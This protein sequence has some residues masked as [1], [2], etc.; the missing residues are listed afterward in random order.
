MTDYQQDL[1]MAKR[2][3]EGLL[4]VEWPVV[5]GVRIAKRCIAAE[6][7]GGD[8]YAC[9]SKHSHTLVAKPK[10]PGVVEYVDTREEQ[11]GIMIGDVAGHGVSSALVMALAS[12]LLTEIAKHTKSPADVLSKANDILL[13]YIEN[14]Q[15]RYITV[16]Y[17]SLILHSKKIIWAKA[18][19]PDALLLKPD[20]AVIPLAGEGCVLGMFDGEVY[21][22]NSY[23]LSSKD[24]LILYTDGLTEAKNNEGLEWGVEGLSQFLT[25]HT[26]LQIE[27][28]LD[29]IFE[30]VYSFSQTTSP[31]DDQ[32]LVIIEVD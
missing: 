2:V 20:G 1:D 26:S 23:A 27:A 13:K 18:G 4:S 10:I 5:S 12:G 21:A 30:E 28:L 7:V 24:R 25:T 14:S 6:S 17:F 29:A 16:L 3:Q 15:I 19:H 22:E 11:L 9:V 32:T 8:F 31:K